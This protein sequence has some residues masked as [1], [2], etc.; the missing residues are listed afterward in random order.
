MEK[1]AARQRPN[2]AARSNRAPRSASDVRTAP[3]QLAAALGR[4]RRVLAEKAYD[5][6]WLRADLRKAGFVPVIPGTRSRKCPIRHDKRHYKDH[7]RAEAVF[8]RPKNFRRGATPLRQ[9][10]PQPRT[11]RRLPV[12]IESKPWCCRL[13]SRHVRGCASM[14]PS[15]QVALGTGS[16]IDL[17]ASPF[18]RV[19][20]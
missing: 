14:W 15:L 10:R 13:E 6:D 20:A 8:C 18:W 16:R 7:W 11:C 2:D 12:L 9:A 19:R 3:A 4:I 5:A 1:R 17:A